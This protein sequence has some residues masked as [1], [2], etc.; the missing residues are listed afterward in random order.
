MKVKLAVAATAIA[1]LVA[2]AAASAHV[3]LHPNSV[4]AGS[5][6]TLYIRV[7]GEQPHANTIK[8][9]VQFPPG[10]LD[11][12]TDPP[13][14]WTSQVIT[15][16]LAHPVQTDDGTIDT[17]VSQIIWTGDDHQ[18][19]IAP[20]QFQQFPISTAIPDNDAGKQ[21]VFK[22]V[23]TYDNGTVVHWIGPASAD[24]PAP[25]INVT[26]KGGVLL[27]V[28]GAEAGPASGQTGLP[29]ATPAAQHSSG[30][31]SKGLATAALIVGI[32]GLLLGAGGLAA[33]V[34][35]RRVKTPA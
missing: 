5:F 16:K 22:A 3:S 2:P 25:T 35:A 28:A 26:P 31:A 34:R 12:N 11:V 27:D 4:P 29:S 30:G 18:G 32:L 9:A 14:G 13:P 17:E 20:D 23:Q 15:Q 10:F 33:A 6:A 19:K 21:L 1:L 24:Q 7:P 8:L